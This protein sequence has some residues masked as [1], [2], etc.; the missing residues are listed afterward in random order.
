MANVPARLVV[1]Q[2]RW[3]Y[4]Q[5]DVCGTPIR[6]A[7]EI[8]MSTFAEPEVLPEAIE[9]TLAA[10]RR[11]G[12]SFADVVDSPLLSGRPVENQTRR[13]TASMVL[14]P[15]WAD[16]FEG[17]WFAYPGDW[18]VTDRHGNTRIM[19]AEQFARLFP[20]GQVTESMP[21]CP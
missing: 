8:S 13:C 20:L 17:P 7:L 9:A 18:R 1:R 4:V 12:A 11:H 14:S 2:A 3:S 21:M 19:G 5:I 10:Y 6:S 15:T 16:T